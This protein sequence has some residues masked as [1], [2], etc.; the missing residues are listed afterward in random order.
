MLFNV[1]NVVGLIQDVRACSPKPQVL[2]GGAAF[3][4][5]PEQP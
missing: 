3:R 4:A 1:P 5:K 2:V